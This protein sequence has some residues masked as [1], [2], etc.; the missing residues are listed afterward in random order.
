MLE[1]DEE[2]GPWRGAVVIDDQG[3]TVDITGRTVTA[4]SSSWTTQPSSDGR[5]WPARPLGTSAPSPPN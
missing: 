4:S 2:R 3:R 1:P 5:A